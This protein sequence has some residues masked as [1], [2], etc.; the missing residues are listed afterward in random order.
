MKKILVLFLALTTYYSGVAQITKTIQ[1]SYDASDFSLEAENGLTYI[2]SDTHNVFFESDTL[3]PALPHITVNILIGPSQSYISHTTQKSFSL[4]ASSIIIAPNS[5]DILDFLN[6]DV[7]DSTDVYYSGIY[8]TSNV[9]YIGEEMIDGAKLLVFDVCP[10][11]YNSITKKLYLLSNLSINIALSEINTRS[12]LLGNLNN[13]Y[14]LVNDIIDNQEDLTDTGAYHA[15]SVG[16]N[17]PTQVNTEGYECIIVTKE[18]MRSAFQQLA[19][20]KTQK[21]VKSKVITVEEI[22]SMYPQY[23]S[24]ELRI[25]Y[26]L[27]NYYNGQYHNLRYA[28]LAGS[29]SNVPSPICYVRYLNHHTYTPTDWFYACFD[30]MNWDSNNNGKLGETDDDVDLYPEIFVSRLP[31]RNVADAEVMVDKIIHYEKSPNISSWSNEILMG[32]AKL[33][34][35]KG[36]SSDAEYRSSKMFDNYISPYWNGTKVKFFDT[37]TSFAGGAS[38]QFNSQN[39][40]TVFSNG[41][42]FIYIYTHGNWEHWKMEEGSGVTINTITQLTNPIN[43][44]I[45]SNA[46]LV[47]EFDNHNDCLGARFLQLANTG[48]VGFW[49]CSKNSYSRVM[50]KKLSS[51]NEFIGEFHKSLFKDIYKNFGYATSMARVKKLGECKRPTLYS[52]RHALFTYNPFGDS[53]MPVYTQIPDVFTSATA[54]L[55]NNLLSVSTGIEGCSICIMSK[56]DYGN[57]YYCVVRDASSYSFDLSH[58]NATDFIVTV[59]KPNYVAFTTEVHK[60][61]ENNVYVQNQTFSTNTTI[62]GDNIYVGNDVT[63]LEAAGDVIVNGGKLTIQGNHRVFIKNGFKVNLGAQ[64]KIN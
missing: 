12:G 44:I 1:L 33:H 29:Q 16:N 17:T 5:P 53:E 25:K 43:T 19:N 7:P 13:M 42:P 39:F 9:E 63:N 31:A 60:N 36:N 4:L 40:K 27:K 32:G 47:S 48:V 54:T 20:W 3:L 59:T 52:T 56:N 62:T 18:F 45:T 61:I 37:G 46:C 30:T 57:Q 38:Y 41:Y 22:D 51:A 23:A 26:A 55:S 49:G 58:T 6:Y 15:P 64:L 28:V 2:D 50:Y 11:R 14:W 10:F 8:P 34:K 35:Q 24:R 21:G